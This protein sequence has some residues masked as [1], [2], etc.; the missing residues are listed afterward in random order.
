MHWSIPVV[1]TQTNSPTTT[2]KFNVLSIVG[3]ILAFF[4]SIVG[5]ILGVIA[6]VQI[7]RTGQRGR[8]LAWAAVIIGV[9]FFIVGIVVDVTVLPHLTAVANS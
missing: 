1:A 7:N 4:L 9:V 5:A 6:L 2:E 3:F 8:G